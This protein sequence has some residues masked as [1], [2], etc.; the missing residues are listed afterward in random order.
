MSMEKEG[1]LK[2]KAPIYICAFLIPFVMMQIFWAICGVYPYGP[3]SILTGDMDLEF[4]NFYS[5]FINIFKSKNDMSYMLAKTLGGDYPGLAAFQLHDPLLF[6]LFLF[7]GAGVA[8][9]IELIF[10][11]QVSFA[12]LF[13]SILLNNRYKRSW[14]SLLFSTAYSFCAFFFGYLV[15]TIYFG[16][17]AILPLV[18]CFFLRFLDERKYLL[19]Y[20][21]TAVYFIFLNYHMGFMLVIF[22]VLLYI[23]RII[24]DTKYIASLKDFIISGITILLLDGFF[25]IRTG[26]SL[27]GE[28][29]VKTADYGFYRRFPMNQLFAS[30]FAGSVQNDL[31]PLIYCSV[32]AVLFALVYF[33][34]SKISLREKLAAL[35]L[36]ASLFVSMWINLFD[37]VWHGFNNPEGFYWRYAYYVSLI[38]ICLGYR[39]FIELTS[40]ENRGKKGTVLLS[41]AAG[42]IIAYMIWLIISGNVYMDPVRYALNFAIVAAIYASV[43]LM[44]SEKGIKRAGVILIFVVSFAEMLYSSRTAYLSL[45][46]AGGVL[47]EMKRFTDDYKEIS[48]AVSYVKSQDDGFYR[49]EKDFDRAVN[50]AALF[51]YI[52]LSHDS[53]CEKDEIIDWLKNFGFCRTVYYTYYNGGSTSFVD[54]LFGVRYYLSRFD[55][56]LKPYEHLPY[57]G[58]YHA[59]RNDHAL[60]MAFTAPEGLLGYAFD[61]GNTFEKQNRIA[62][63]W[64]TPGDIYI[65][66][67][68]TTETDGVT[69][70]GQG[71]Y[72]KTEEDGAVVYEISIEKEL[73]LYFYFDAPERQPCELF[74]NGESFGP[75][76]TEKHWNILCA[77]VYKPGDKVNIRLVPAQDNITVLDACFYYE[78]T[79]ALAKW[80][81]TAN[82]LG[83]TTGEVNEVSSSHL[84]F[85]TQN[86]GGGA[87][88]VTIPYDNAWKIKVDGKRVKQERAMQMLTGISVP[89]GK[90]TVEMKYIPEGSYAGAFVSFA[91]LI[92]LICN[93]RF[94]KRS[95]EKEE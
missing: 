60:P 38:L 91:G 3:S 36:L 28:K 90:H 1:I 17:L 46:A 32:A 21:I 6:I 20:T 7:P 93:M 43:M 8:A 31:K 34:S 82:A 19:P 18:V 73:P 87:V 86:D 53:S 70:D 63:Y 35:F 47:P 75:Y 44:R 40:E 5:Y 77:G 51:D 79:D 69:G 54:C 42:I 13:A 26:L 95:K 85:E 56:V 84:F 9:G 50:D 78:D 65:K 49:L 29:T 22:L 30:L 27:L 61:E 25:L 64:G 92:M 11:L 39:G 45:N 10:T 37:A 83:R 48:S 81:E 14:M 12:G 52:G 94:M 89:D 23:S 67:L 2:R 33:I 74:V 15:L 88:I 55:E 62:S 68:S 57:E 80:A 16:C 72:S 59:Y 24:C 76:F 58:K 41:A 66:A 71:N 4:V